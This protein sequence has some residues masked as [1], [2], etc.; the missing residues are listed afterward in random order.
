MDT[1]LQQLEEKNVTT[2]DPDEEKNFIYL[3]IDEP[4]HPDA[5]DCGVAQGIRSVFLA[6]FQ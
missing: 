4:D 5:P 3:R 2:A 6:F 1:Y